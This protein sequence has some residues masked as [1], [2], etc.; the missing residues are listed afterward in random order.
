MTMADDADAPQRVVPGYEL[1]RP[2]GRGGMAVAYL[3]RQLSLGRRVVLKFLFRDPGLDPIEQAA[4]FRRE[5]ELMASL[6]HPNIATIFDFGIDDGQ[7]FLVMEY[8]EGG[9]LRNQMEPGRPMAAERVRRLLRAL[10]QALECLHQHGILHRDLKPE[11]I[12]MARED[13]PKVSDFGIAVPEAL[14]GSL[15]HSGHFA[16]TIGYMAPEVQYR[17]PVDERA[18]QYA[19]AAVT[20]ELLTGQLPLGVF[21]DPSQVSPRLHR[22]VDVALRR[23]LREDRSDRFATIRAFGDALDRALATPRRRHRV[24][25][26]TS[27][28]ALAAFGLLA[29]T[30]SRQNRPLTLSP[31]E[32]VAEGRVR[33]SAPPNA[34]ASAEGRVRAS[35]PPNARAAES[36]ANAPTSAGAVVA[37]V[38]AP[39]LTNSVG[40]RLVLIPHG[41][42]FMGSPDAD[43]YARAD[44]KPRHEVVVRDAFYMG[45]CEV[46]VREFRRF[47]EA[48]GHRTRP[49]SDG[50][51]GAIYDRQQNKTVM[52]P[53]LNWRNPGFKRAQADDEPVVQ[54]CREDAIAYCEWLT[55]REGVLYRLPT[56]AEWE[57]ACRAGSDAPWSFGNDKEALGDY[58]WF[59]ENAGATTHPVGRKHPN[60]F[61]LYDVYGNVWEWCSDR[62]LPGYDQPD[63]LDEDESEASN[64]RGYVIRGGSFGSIATEEARS[65]SRRGAAVGYRYH[66]CGFRVRRALS[67]PE[68]GV[69]SP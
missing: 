22:S 65:A 43:P 30:A 12:L 3:A 49:E 41:T 56:E 13:T 20:Y 26:I 16:G 35:A 15:T 66:S 21:P 52:R 25:F 51:G 55:R 42:F 45:A 63:S 64:R 59:R 46:T 14:V 8:V 67:P 53:E 37:S 62:Y 54:V 27:A 68:S 28:A 39:L 19:L 6:S 57:Y 9:D 47:V 50:R 58:A 24:W 23:A 44:E 7:P 36:V 10:V 32:R 18:D 4:R 5:A 60:A 34:D 61:G 38:P 1:L 2:L 40:M 31:W 33:A 17:L 11:N 29:F 48:T 69:R